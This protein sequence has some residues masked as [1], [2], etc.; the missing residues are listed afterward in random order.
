MTDQGTALFPAPAGTGSPGAAPGPSDPRSG[1]GEPHWLQGTEE[2]LRA[3]PVLQAWLAWVTQAAGGSIYL[4]PTL[5]LAASEGAAPL[6][7]VGRAGA[8]A[9]AEPLASLAALAPKIRQVRLTPGLPLGLS[10]SGRRLI[11]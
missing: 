6:V 4:H 9:D 10:L 3:G 1:P 11:G 2:I 5:V 8:Q 7:Y